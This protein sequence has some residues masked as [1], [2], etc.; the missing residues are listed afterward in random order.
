MIKQT[1]VFFLTV[2]ILIAGCAK[3]PEKTD[4][5]E[6]ARDIYQEIADKIAENCGN[7]EIDSGEECDFKGFGKCSTYDAELVGQLECYNCKVSTSLCQQKEEC[8][9][10]CSGNG[11]CA[12]N[13]YNNNEAFCKC[14]G[15]MSGTNCEKCKDEFHFDLD[16]TCISDGS[17]T[18]T[19]CEN[20]KEECVIVAGQAAC[21]CKSPWTGEDCKECLNDYYYSEGE[22]KSRYCSSGELECSGYEKC[23]DGNGKPEC[24]CAGKYQDPNDCSKC[25]PDYDF[26]NYGDF[27]I[28]EKEV[29]CRHNPD[30][31]ENSIDIAKNYTIVYTDETGWSEPEYC[32]W[33]CPENSYLK[34]NKCNLTLI[35]TVPYNIKYP[36]GVDKKGVLY[37]CN[38]N[39]I[40]SISGEVSL[41]YS[42][43]NQIWAGRFGPGN[44]IYLNTGGH[45]IIDTENWTHM[46]FKNLTTSAAGNMSVLK[47]GKIT[48]GNSVIEKTERVKIDADYNF[49]SSVV[50]DASGNIVN[51]YRNG[52]I[53]VHDENLNLIWDRKYENTVFW[54]YPALD[55]KGNVYIPC[56]NS[57]SMNIC[58]IDIA[59]GDLSDRQI[60]LDSKCETSSHLLPSVSI[61][62]NGEVYVLQ[63]GVLKVFNAENTLILNTQT[64]HA[65]SYSQYTVAPVITD[66]GY[67]YFSNNNRIIC[68]DK[69]GEEIWKYDK[70][71]DYPTYF[72]HHDEVLYVF[73]QNNNMLKFSAP[74]NLKGDW[75]QIFHD[76]R[77]SNSLAE[78]EFIPKPPTPVLVSPENGELVNKGSVEFEWENNDKS[79][80][81]LMTIEGRNY[82]E[83]TA[84]PDSIYS[85]VLED[86]QISDSIIWKAAAISDEGAV[87]IAQSEFS[88]VSESEIWEFYSTKDFREAPIT[89]NSDDFILAARSDDLVLISRKD[90]SINI[91]TADVLGYY[92]AAANKKGSF[93]GLGKERGLLFE[94]KS[95]K[96]YEEILLR[97][98]YELTVP[99][100]SECNDQMI[101]FYDWSGSY[102]MKTDIYDDLV[103]SFSDPHVNNNYP[104]VNSRG[105]VFIDKLV[106]VWGNLINDDLGLECDNQILY[107]EFPVCSDYGSVFTSYK[108]Q[109][110][111]YSTVILP[112]RY[113]DVVH[114][115]EIITHD[116]SSAKCFLYAGTPSQEEWRTIAT[117]NCS[118]YMLK[119]AVSSDGTFFTFSKK[120]IIEIRENE[121]VVRN[122][123]IS[124][125]DILDIALTE[126]GR[127]FV[128]TEN[129]IMEIK[130]DADGANPYEWSQYRGNA[131][132]TGSVKSDNCNIHAQITLL[133]PINSSQL[134]PKRPLFKWDA[135]DPEGNV[136]KY[137]FKIYS[138]SD[139][140]YSENDITDKFF[141]LPV[142]LEW[143]KGY[144]WSIVAKDGESGNNVETAYF[145]RE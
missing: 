28:N 99:L 25:L 70:V 94:I 91:F 83:I 57:A 10:N 33:E 75:P 106:S 53:T 141:Q 19:G 45:G 144:N 133:E 69:D 64:L 87:S 102:Y 8:D 42:V 117:W 54:E 134:I 18:E 68:I 4:I 66:N 48:Y 140:I 130:H 123:Q 124:S 116:Y 118:N 113:L 122:E 88:R 40:F 47:N 100:I 31:A 7:G 38:Y 93:F 74:G 41:V 11:S 108:N 121:G 79:L 1:A 97:D 30:A 3:A 20:E 5:E 21:Q 29:N 82:D 85:A 129:K 44:N 65:S 92:G 89:V 145:V 14:Y 58:I 127:L 37:G 59:T 34:D 125:T 111:I 77:L 51:V 32:E 135:F 126:E 138:G 17:C 139:L 52:S 115:G 24:V 16:G 112:G 137:D 86:V 43:N 101:S 27:C 103:P 128:M 95:P 109:D 9:L 60:V 105:E 136:L 12:E 67:I 114:N 143:G 107:N 61:G 46:I 131:G 50:S 36:V 49:E 84:G 73:Y 26:I 110:N 15:N 13:T 2:L 6:I 76:A 90:N 96:Y 78:A 120:N 119:F 80:E 132:R 104:V 22:C 72:I 98:S 35:E 71:A 56:C 55:K 23:Y 62:E 142:D 63:K 81:H 39:E